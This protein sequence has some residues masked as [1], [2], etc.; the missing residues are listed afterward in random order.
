MR[1]LSSGGMDSPFR[2]SRTRLP[3]TIVSTVTTSDPVPVVRRRGKP[4]PTPAPGLSAG[5][6]ETTGHRRRQ[7]GETPRA[8]P[9][10]RSS[11]SSTA[12]TAAR[13]AAAERA[14]ADLPVRMQ[15]PRVPGRPEQQRHRQRPAQHGGRRVRRRHVRE[16]PRQEPPGPESGHVRTRGQSPRR[17]PRPRSRRPAA[18]SAASRRGAGRT[19]RS[20]RRAAVASRPAHTGRSWTSFRISRTFMLATI[21]RRSSCILNLSK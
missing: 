13:A 20:R 9:R 16:H 18:E 3:A 2:R 15:H 8:A 5:T 10:S 17:P 21:R 19:R 14:A 11:P 12:C 1:R 4:G 7:A 6:A